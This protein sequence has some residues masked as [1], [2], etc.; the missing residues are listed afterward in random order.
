MLTIDPV[1]MATPLTSPLGLNNSV[2]IKL[3]PLG[4]AR[5]GPPLVIG[6]GSVT[7]S[8]IWTTPPGGADSSG[9]CNDICRVAVV[10]EPEPPLVDPEVGVV[11]P[12]P[13]LVEPDVPCAKATCVR[14]KEMPTI[15]Q[16]NLDKVFK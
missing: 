8:F 7:R 11:V 16:P 1:V 5:R 14:R 3:A 6:V 9:M 12:G 2:P 15:V 13:P 4:M 10:Q